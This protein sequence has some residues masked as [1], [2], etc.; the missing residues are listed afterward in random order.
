MYK[1]LSYSVILKESGAGYVFMGTRS[2]LI[3]AG[4][5]HSME[6]LRCKHQYSALRL[7]YP[8]SNVGYTRRFG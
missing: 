4:N 7:R 6:L 3:D 5:K 2:Y 1:Y 8:T